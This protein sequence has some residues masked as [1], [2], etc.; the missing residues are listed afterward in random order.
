MRQ[1]SGCQLLAAR[2]PNRFTRCWKRRQEKVPVSKLSCR[3]FG[4]PRAHHAVPTWSLFC[5]AT[6]AQRVD[7]NGGVF[8]LF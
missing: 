7:S 6:Y 4:R 3:N 8:Q 1:T 2:A 5:G